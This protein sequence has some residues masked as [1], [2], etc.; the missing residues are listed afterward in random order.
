MI[1]INM[2]YPALFLLFAFIMFFQKNQKEQI[3]ENNQKIHRLNQKLGEVS[4]VQNKILHI[5]KNTDIMQSM[6]LDEIKK[7]NG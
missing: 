6:T 1:E 2:F 3:I 5:L 7:S 4:D